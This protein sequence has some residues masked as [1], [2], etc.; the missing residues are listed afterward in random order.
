M[1]NLHML[2]SSFREAIVESISSGDIREISE[3]G[4]PNGWCTY[5]SDLLQKY[6]FDQGIFT[7]YIS[8]CY[9]YGQY[10]ESHAWLETMDGTV[11]DIT[12]DQYRYNKQLTFSDPVYIGPREDGFHNQFRLY[13]PKA[14]DNTGDGVR[15]FRERYEAVMK[16]LK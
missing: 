1:T 4:F 14:Y 12:G 13:S 10:G 11:I 5:A 16:H 6:L 2:V 8:G 7:W 15:G 3:Y 9:D